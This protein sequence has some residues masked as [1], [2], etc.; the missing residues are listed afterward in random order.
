MKFTVTFD[1]EMKLTETF[2]AYMK[3]IETGFF[4]SMASVIWINKKLIKRW[5]AYVGKFDVKSTENLGIV[6]GEVS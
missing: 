4:F 1:A 3:F 5:G 6:V 2:Y